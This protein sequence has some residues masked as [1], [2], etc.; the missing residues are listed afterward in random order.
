MADETGNWSVSSVGLQ[1]RLG[2]L[3]WIPAGDLAKITGGTWTI[4]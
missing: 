4:S 1:D 2:I 3:R